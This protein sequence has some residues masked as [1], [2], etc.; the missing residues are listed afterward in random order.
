[1]KKKLSFLLIIGLTIF[2]IAG[3]MVSAQSADEGLNEVITAEDGEESDR[4]ENLTAYLDFLESEKEL[5]SLDRIVLEK[6]L[7]DYYGEDEEGGLEFTTITSVIDRYIT[8]EID[9]GQSF[10]ILNNLNE[11][12]LNGFN[13]KNMVDTLNNFHSDENSGQLFF[14]TAL[15]MRK[16]S[17]VDK[18]AEFS[19]KFSNEISS[20][21]EKNGK[22]EI[23]ELKKMASTYRKEARD[24]EREVNKINNNHGFEKN[25][26]DNNGVKPNK[27][28]N[29]KSN[30]KKNKDRGKSNHSS[31]K[32]KGKNK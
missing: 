20:L 11:A 10:F 1:M 22:L 18:D 5:D 4:F 27:G 9:L 3:G 6:K 13:E 24:K 23:S 14:Q 28:N 31:G 2:L 30:D 32:A 19:E 12:V 26:N 21:L 15:E 25:N 17:R 7:A 29:D 8:D 16:L